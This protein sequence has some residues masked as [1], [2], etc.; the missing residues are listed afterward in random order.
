MACGLLVH[1]ENGRAV[2]VEGDKNSPVNRGKICVKGRYALEYIY[3]PDRLRHPLK[4]IG[5]RGEGK[6]QQIG[7]EEALDTIAN[8][9]S[10]AR[11]NFGAESIAFVKGSFKSVMDSYLNR[12]ANVFGSPNVVTEGHVC[13]APRTMGAMVTLGF[14]PLQDYDYPPNCIVVWGLNPA[15]TNLNRYSGIARALDMGARLVVID[16]RNINLAKKADLWL[17]PRPGSDL[18]LALGMINVI[19]NENLYN[20]DFVDRWTVGF[21]ELGSHV[22]DYSPEKVADIA[23]VT[24]DAIREAARLYAQNGPACIAHGNALDQNVNSVQT[25]RALAILVAIT[26]NLGIPGGEISTTPPPALGARSPELDLREKMPGEKLQNRLGTDYKTAPTQRQILPQSLVRAIL[27]EEPYPIKAAYVQGSNPLLVFSNARD[28]YQ[29]FREVGFSA[30][31]DL[32]MTPTAALADIV[33]PVASDLEFDSIREPSY[34]SI[35]CC[36]Q[37]VVEIE[38]CWSDYR[39]ISELARRLGLDEYFPDSDEECLDMLLQPAGLTFREFKEVLWIS[40]NKQYCEHERQGFATPSGK[41]ELVCSQLKNWGFDPLP[42]FYELLETPGSAPGLTEEYPLIFTTYKTVQY[43][44]SCNRQIDSLRR[45]R[46][47]PLVLIHPKTAG[48][49]GLVKGEW[50]Y[51]ETKRGRIKQKVALD[52]SIDPRIVAAEFGWWFP[53]RG[54]V[55]MYDWADS[56]INILTDDQPPYNREIGSTNLRGILCRVYKV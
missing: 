28:T 37:K 47:D 11:D 17:K 53:E 27:K 36:Q 10:W 7:W 6:W 18:A 15:E 32:F 42:V 21:S 40:G 51:I 13:H 34:P 52:N 50:A 45:A 38:D 5:E 35:I 30:V 3:H 41:V 20:R 22:Q 12:L 24:A 26:G 9:L 4:R 19:I 16:P 44:H 29:A 55:D 33:L 31:A 14:N 1:V 8:G 39:I 56:N 48:K 23:W 46:P 43:R 2:K 49:A 54:A 25:G